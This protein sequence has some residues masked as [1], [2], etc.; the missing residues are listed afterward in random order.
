MYMEVYRK[1][2]SLRPKNYESNRFFFKFNNGKA[3][4]QV[5]GIHHFGKMPQ[6]V[7]IF[8]NLPNPELYTGHCFR[9]SSAT[10][11]VDSGAN[12]TTLKRHGAWKSSSVAEG[13]IEDSINNKIEVAD[14]ILKTRTI[15]SSSTSAGEAST[16]A[17]DALN[18]A[19]L[20]PLITDCS[21]CN[22]TINIT[23]N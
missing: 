19:L 12:L 14:R 21:N 17:G 11:L 5:V 2:C 8:L 6:L 3:C 23:N 9:R 18:K 15:T 20:Q 1:Y 10:I 13:Y 22:I 16:S 7:A 4:R